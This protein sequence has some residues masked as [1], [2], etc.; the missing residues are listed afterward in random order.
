[1]DVRTIIELKMYVQTTF[2]VDCKTQKLRTLPF[3]HFF[4]LDVMSQYWRHPRTVNTSHRHEQCNWKQKV[5]TLNSNA[6]HFIWVPLPHAVSLIPL[7]MHG[8]AKA[9][10][11][12]N[13][14]LPICA[15]RKDRT[16]PNT[17]PQ[18]RKPFQPF[19]LKYKTPHT[20]YE[21][22]QKQMTS[23]KRQIKTV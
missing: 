4:V 6:L 21:F 18:E 22:R 13:V 9:T 11:K 12:N 23:Q 15:R 17:L 5:I 19:H 14:A 7:T 20:S 8:P 1:M 3:V 2:S 10:N 16:R